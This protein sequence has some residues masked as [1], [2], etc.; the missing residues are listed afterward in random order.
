MGRTKA[1]Y[2]TIDE[3]V[4]KEIRRLHERYPKLGHHGLAEALRE[5]GVPVEPD[6]LKHFMK[7]EGLHAEREWRPW[8]WRGLPWWMGGPP[9]A[10]K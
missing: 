7:E 1:A 8:R 5:A 6:E 9:E 2:R 4:A 10:P 3:R